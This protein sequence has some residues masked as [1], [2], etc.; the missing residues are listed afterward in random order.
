MEILVEKIT[1][2]CSARSASSSD[3]PNFLILP[4]VLTTYNPSAVG[5][6]LG[7]LPQ[8]TRHGVHNKPVLHS[9][10]D[11]LFI[12]LVGIADLEVLQP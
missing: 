7:S 12:P 6:Q 9:V 2:H 10:P 5:F 3:F 1:F 4:V 8:S 11:R